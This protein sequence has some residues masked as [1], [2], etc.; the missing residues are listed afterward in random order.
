MAGSTLDRRARHHLL[1]RRA[2]P[3]GQ[4]P[5]RRGG[6]GMTRSP[7]SQRPDA[8]RRSASLLPGFAGTDAARLAAERCSPRASAASACFGSNIA[9]GAGAAARRSPPRSARPTRDAVHRHRRGGRR[10][11]PAAHPRPAAPC[12]G[13]AAL[14]AARRPRPAPSAVGAP[15]RA[16]AAPRSGINLDLAPGRRR[17]LQPGQPGHRRA[18]LR[19]RPRAGRRPRRGL[20]ARAAVR[21]GSPACAKHFPGHGDTARTPTSRCPSSTSTLDDAARARAAA[22]RG[23]DR[24]RRAPRHDLAHRP[25]R[26]RSRA[27]RRR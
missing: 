17:Q 10:R 26:A 18:Q 3:D 6:E 16:R 20:D 21:P 13:N 15:G 12:P 7:R 8:P 14:G 2:G 4:R 1:P 25:A 27:A 22:V 5:R 9:D 24:G 23:G 11:H 19:R